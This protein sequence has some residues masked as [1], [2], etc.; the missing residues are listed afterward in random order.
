MTRSKYAWRHRAGLLTVGDVVERIPVTRKTVYNMVDR[1]EL[2]AVRFGGRV[3]IDAQ[4][5]EQYLA[6]HR[7]GNGSAAAHGG[8]PA[9]H[10]DESPSEWLD[11]M[12]QRKRREEDDDA[13][14]G[15]EPEAEDPRPPDIWRPGGAKRTSETSP[16]AKSAPKRSFAQDLAE[17]ERVGTD[18]WDDEKERKRRRLQKERAAAARAKSQPNQ[19]F[20]VF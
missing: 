8:S 15:P 3:F 14:F 20:E 18:V 16:P 19:P 12:W 11:S 2:P 5:F 9:V 6:E 10:D 13:L 7:T 17:V 4:G 1:G